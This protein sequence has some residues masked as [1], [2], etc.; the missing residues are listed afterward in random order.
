[1]ENVR[2]FSLFGNHELRA[3]EWVVVIIIGHRDGTSEK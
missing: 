1:M 3:V 2:V